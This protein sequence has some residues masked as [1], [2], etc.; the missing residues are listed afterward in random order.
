[1]PATGGQGLDEDAAVGAEERLP[2]IRLSLRRSRRP[3]A[4]VQLRLPLDSALRPFGI[5]AFSV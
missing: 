5:A 1:M 4:G 3:D 2:L